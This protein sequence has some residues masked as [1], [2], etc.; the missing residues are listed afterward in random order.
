MSKDLV[1]TEL[2]PDVKTR[3]EFL[4]LISH[5][6]RTPINNIMGF[7]N[8]LAKETYGDLNI[9][10]KEYLGIIQTCS[11]YLIDLTQDLLD[12]TKLE[13]NKEILQLERFSVQELIDSCCLMVK[14]RTDEKNLILESYNKDGIKSI[15]A[16]KKRLHQVLLNLLS[17]SV[18][19]TD[20]GSV[21]LSLEER[22]DFYTFTVS[23]T[24]CGIPE[25]KQM[26]LFSPYYRESSHKEGTGLGLVLTK[27]FVELHGGWITTKSQKGEGTTVTVAIPKVIKVNTYT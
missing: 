10:Q 21:T 18:K 23:D 19:F 4:T 14:H 20:T 15:T 11:K 16:D 12:L 17:N 26:N 13:N 27:Q 7:S 9:K 2:K 1:V 5:D 6:L 25:E 22:E 3:I 24:G 8:I